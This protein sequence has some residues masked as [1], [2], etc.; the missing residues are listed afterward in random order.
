MGGWGPFDTLALRGSRSKAD[1][2]YSLYVGCAGIL[3]LESAS[4][5]VR[6]PVPA[7]SPCNLLTAVAA[8]QEEA[9]QAGIPMLT[10]SL[11]HLHVSLFSVSWQKSQGFTDP[12]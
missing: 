5:Y 9:F 2:S 4:V 10:T 6:L 12:H 8:L 11:Q 3:V 7:A 1:V